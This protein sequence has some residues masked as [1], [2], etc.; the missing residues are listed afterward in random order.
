[1][2]VCVLALLAANTLN[3]GADLGAVAAGGSL[4][5]RG[6]VPAVWLVVPVALL[7]LGLQFFATYQTIFKVFKWLALVLFAYVITGILV[8][9]SPLTLL[10]ATFVPHVELSRDFITAVVAVLGTTISPYLFFWQASSEVDEMRAAGRRS[11]A[12]R[13]G[14]RTSEL[15]AARTDIVIG[16]AFSQVVMYFIIMTS[17]TVLHAH[18]RTDVQSAEQAATALAPLAGPLAFVL[19]AAGIIGTGLLAIPVLSGSAAYAL[20]E[21]FGFRGDLSA[22]PRYRPTFYAVIALATITGIALNFLRVD[23]IRALFLAAVVN[24]AIAAPLLVLITL[25]GADP[26]FMM[27]RVSGRW[28]RSLTGIAAAL[29]GAATVAMLATMVIHQ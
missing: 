29:M 18:G 10:Q 6:A 15:R 23:P 20:K 7:V 25:L 19:F 1:V 14:V 8:H 5:S 28:S 12:E 2:G 22:K 24:G 4:L 16:M 26:K 9:P 3:L 27:E 13:R 21:F 11:E 17:A